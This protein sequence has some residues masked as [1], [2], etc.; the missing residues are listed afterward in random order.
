MKNKQYDI[1]LETTKKTQIIIITDNNIYINATFQDG[2][3]I[4]Y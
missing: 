4:R 3:P 1:K 2:N